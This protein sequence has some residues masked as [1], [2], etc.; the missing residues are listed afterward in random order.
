MRFPIVAVAVLLAVLPPGGT[1]IDDDGDTHEGGIEAIAAAGITL[2]C[3]PPAND[4]FCPEDTVTRGQM[5]AFLARARD[6][7]DTT[8]D[9]FTDDDGHPFEAA[10]DRIA[11]AGIALGCDPPAND[12]YCP[13]QEMTRG[14]MAMMLA[15]AFEPPPATTNHFLDDEGMVS[16]SAIDRIADAGITR[17]CNPPANDNFC[18]NAPVTRAQMAT[19]L[20]RALGLTP[21]VPPPRR[22]EFVSREA[23]GAA[24]PEVTEMVP[25]VV[26]RLTVHHTGEAGGLTG[27]ARIREMQEWHMVGQ[28]WP[29]LAYHVVIGR[30]GTVYEGRD[31]A[32]RGDTGTSYDTTGHYLVVLEGNFEVDRPSSAQW[33]SLV[34][35]LAWAADHYEVS[36]DTISGHSDHA[37]TLCPGQ[38]LEHRIHTG[39]LADAVSA[40]MA[41][42][43]VRSPMVTGT[44]S[45]LSLAW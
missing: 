14:Q 36:P 21:L 25:H 42:G 26:D 7:P 35:V 33:D 13:D 9:F 16:E 19:F 37:A 24:A 30:D 38:H 28:G 5:A 45:R 6:L 34:A 43:Q 2:G 11:A 39:E 20:T 17:G 8:A 23:W 15:R 12:R 31:P 3:N 4:R 10:I 29:D 18:P 40:A 41:Q 1:F 44:A 27:P 22:V 32:Y